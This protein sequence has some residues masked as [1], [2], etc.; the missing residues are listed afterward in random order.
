M[1]G[2]EQV[3]LGGLT[4]SVSHPPPLLV[5]GGFT[6]SIAVCITSDVALEK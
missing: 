5:L 2:I 1:Y 4:T 6:T 3:E